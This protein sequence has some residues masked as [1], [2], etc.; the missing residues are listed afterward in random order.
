MY[1][2]RGEILPKET[3][4]NILCYCLELKETDDGYLILSNTPIY[5]PEEPKEE[6]W[7]PQ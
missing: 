1:S 3:L 5:R 4:E 2:Q 6:V 7:T